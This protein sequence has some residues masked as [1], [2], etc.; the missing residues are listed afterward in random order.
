MRLF[1]AIWPPRETA[2]ALERWARPLAGRFTQAGKIHLT[3]AFLGEADAARASGAARR[4][5]EAAFD[6][7]LEEARY[8]RHNQIVWAGPRETP[9]ALSRLAGGLQIELYRESFILERRPFAAHVT[10]LRKAAE[11]PLPPLPR[12]HWPVREFA[13]VRSAGGAYE[14]LERFALG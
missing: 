14:T 9:A 6:L 2:L 7:P 4:V 1:F 5:Q 8:W 11:Q 13:L 3:L 12:V 10:L